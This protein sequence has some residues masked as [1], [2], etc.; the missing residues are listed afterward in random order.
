MLR[1]CVKLAQE[2]QRVVIFIEPIALYMK[3]DLHQ[4]GDGLWSFDYLPPEKSSCMELGE[5]GSYGE[6]KDLCILSYANGYYLSRQA[7]AQLAK[8]GINCT[9]V[10]LR[11]LAPLND[12][13]ILQAV[14]GFSNVLIVDECRRTGSISEALVTLITES[15]QFGIDL[16]NIQRITAQ[17]CFI[18]LGSASYEVLPSTQQIVDSAEQM[19]AANN[20]KETL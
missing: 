7:E 11:W 8:K 12:A 13:A 17:D 5:L 9:V 3:K 16:P 20:K 6:G 14:E 10:D 18:P 4:D 2:Q 19:I 1:T 15:K